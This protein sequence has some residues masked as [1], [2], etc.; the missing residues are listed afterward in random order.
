M[1]APNR[2]LVITD[3]ATP[4]PEHWK[5]LI[6]EIKFPLSVSTCG[7]K[8]FAQYIKD[9]VSE[10]IQYSL[11]GKQEHEI[12]LP[13]LGSADGFSGKR[14]EKETYFS[15]TSYVYPPTIFKYDINNNI[16]SVYKKP[17]IQ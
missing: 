14:E 7:R 1:H 16:S 17:A 13:G 15:F 6:P 9:A 4:T 12:T 5:D 10:V 8:F 2:K 11:D 3:A